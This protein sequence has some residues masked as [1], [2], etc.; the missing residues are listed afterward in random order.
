MQSMDRNTVIGFVLLAILL[1]AYMFISSKNSR[2]LEVQKKLYDDSV[3][4]V[5]LQKQ[6]AIAK[7][8]STKINAVRDTTA[9]GKIF[10]GDEKTITVENE[11][12]NI[13]FT[14]KGAQA[15][16][17]SSEKIQVG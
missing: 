13:V 6:A 1:F 10:S 12:L 8:D 4:L 15:K 3:A 7:K 17:C 16:I 9:A 2:A 11:V 14:N 5:S